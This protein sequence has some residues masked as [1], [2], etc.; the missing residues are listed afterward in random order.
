MSLS[1]R[2]RSLRRNLFRRNTVE[3]D[4]EEE[5]ESTLAALIDEK[6]SRGLSADGARRA[7][8]VELRIEPVKERVRD[9]RTGAV[10]EHVTQDLRYAWRH[11]RRSPGFAPAAMLTLALGSGANTAMFSKRSC[12]GRCN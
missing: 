9:A 5:L 3:L 4:L 2:L 10:V 7:A 12:I 1:T 8:L 6:R 11:V